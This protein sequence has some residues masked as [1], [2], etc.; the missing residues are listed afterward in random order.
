MSF[1]RTV[2]ILIMVFNISWSHLQ[3]ATTNAI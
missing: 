1:D 3:T 2:L